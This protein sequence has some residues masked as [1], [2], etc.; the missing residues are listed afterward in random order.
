M[1]YPESYN[2]VIGKTKMMLD[3]DYII[4]QDEKILDVT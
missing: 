1:L 2:R 3:T 4:L